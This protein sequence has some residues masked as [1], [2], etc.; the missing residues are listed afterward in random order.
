MTLG[1]K[2]TLL[3]N[4]HKLSQ[5]DLAE[6]LNVSRQSISKWETG[7]SVPEL[8]KLILLSDLF[9]ISLD[10]LIKDDA[11]V[12]VPSQEKPASIQRIL[13]FILLGAGFLSIILGALFATELI[14]FGF[15]FILYG[16]LCLTIKK[17]IGLIIGWFSVILLFLSEWVLFATP[18][19]IGFAS[20]S[21]LLFILML[22][23]TVRAYKNGQ[24]FQNFKK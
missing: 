5:S 2:I 12:N 21:L 13:G 17:H 8:D 6:K 24:I 3:R 14:I 1:E 15:I 11:R 9:R 7:A 22:I 16:I 20:P 10:E 18:L 23:I 19:I 4:E